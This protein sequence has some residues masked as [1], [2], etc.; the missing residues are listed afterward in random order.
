MT[1]ELSSQRKAAVRPFAPVNDP[2]KSAHSSG[3]R[4]RQ[5]DLIAQGD[6]G[7][8]RDLYEATSARL[9]GVVFRILADRSESEDVLQ[10]VYLVVWRQAD[11]F[12]PTRAS[13]MTWLITIARNRAIDR[14]RERSRR[15]RT[16]EIDAG[17]RTPCPAPSPL[18]AL[19]LSDESRRVERG[20]E[21]LDQ[22]SAWIIRT[23]FLEG[24]TYETLSL[25]TGTP[26]GT[27]KSLARR[28]LQKLRIS[29]A[30]ADPCHPAR[31]RASQWSRS[32]SPFDRADPRRI[33]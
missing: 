28:G 10:E 27:V 16:E 5:L 17:E 33:R 19:Q 14:L 18:A 22:K 3:E 12:D 21:G 4:A 2:T 26:L 15:P 20:L 8:L 6:R 7:A 9:L 31:S 13:A 29:L 32:E 24:A 1:V 11:R 25:R 23:A 30:D